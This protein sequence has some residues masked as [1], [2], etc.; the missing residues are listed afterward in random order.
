MLYTMKLRIGLLLI[1]PVLLLARAKPDGIP[2]PL[3][4]THVT[5]ID[6]AGGELRRD[7][8]VVITGDRISAIGPSAKLSAPADAKVIDAT[9]IPDSRPVGHARALVRERHVHSVYRQWRDWRAADV[10]KL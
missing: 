6:V 1:L 9:P 8:T 5:I 7:M 4:L 3:A 2:T 10:R